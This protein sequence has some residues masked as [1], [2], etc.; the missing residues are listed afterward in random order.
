VAS[1]ARVLGAIGLL[2]VG[3]TV[4]AQPASVSG[5]TT[6]AETN[7]VGAFSI[8]PGHCGASGPPSG[9]YMEI[10]VEGI[11]VPNTGSSCSGSSGAF[12]PLAQGDTGL[13]T[14]A[15]QMDPVPT[16]DSA[17]NS[18]SSAIIHPARF[19]ANDL[20][21]AT[22]CA[23]QT[24]NP[25][26]TGGCAPGTS[27]F[28]VPSLEAVAPGQP[29]C[30]STSSV[31]CLF[32]DL[33]SLGVTWAGYRVGAHSSSPLTELQ[34][35][36]SKADTTCANSS[37]CASAGVVDSP[38]SVATCVSNTEPG[39]CALFGTFD[40][41]TRAYTLGVSTG[42]DIGL[43]PHAVL[44]LI[45]R[46]TFTSL[47]NGSQ[48]GNPGSDGRSG[49]GGQSSGD[50]TS[51][52]APTGEPSPG[53]GN[54]SSAATSDPTTGDQELSGTFT[55]GSSSCADA[56][57]SGS[58]F[59]ISYSTLTEGN[60]SSTCDGGA[61]TLLQPGSTGLGIGTF[62]PNPSPTFDGSG[63]SLA[64]SIVMPVG[65]NGHAL[66]LATS[67]E[68]VQDAPQG[69]PIFN[70]PEAIIEGSNLAVD[71]SSLNVTYDG[72]PNDTCAQS[73]GVG[74]WLE[75]SRVA[76]GT[77]D[78][79]SG[80]FTLEW[81]TSQDFSGGSGEVDFKLSGHFSGTTA[82]ADQAQ[83][84]ALAGSTYAVTS[85]SV[86]S[87]SFDNTVASASS[88]TPSS[89]PSPPITTTPASTPLR[90]HDGKP[91][92]RI[93]AALKTRVGD[94]TVSS[95]QFPLFIVALGAVVAIAVL[96][97]GRR[98]RKAIHEITEEQT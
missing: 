97:M 63:N 35:L 87:Q 46:G 86:V 65:Y 19:L 58:Y 90:K 48:A 13:V 16:F 26:S 66:G 20:G 11:P 1:V 17:G 21:L 15:Y 57:P 88:S 6:A 38:S 27:G 30:P 50:A 23:N 93:Q 5:A 4:I 91:G 40:P 31:D 64:N 8:S 56:T 78:P 62:T 29:R 55:L 67:P 36:I 70:P 98:S 94:R 9:S 3:L 37:G 61:Y 39:S 96:W 7:L 95:S 45:L 83:V 43:F 73:F 75:G 84:Q 52:A 14:G 25:T 77:Y 74:C 60:T 68:D 69:P 49:T 28:P 80:D 82:A 33:S 51:V 81:Y 53:S 44:Q 59:T 72:T 47:L 18:E 32:G 79:T 41:T 54:S 22:T 2:I 76:T 89:A 24:S 10:E 92:H 85:T 42:L 71:L 34:S 12:T